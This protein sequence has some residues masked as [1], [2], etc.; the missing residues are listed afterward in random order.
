MNDWYFHL[1]GR[2]P[3]G[4]EDMVT[5]DFVRVSA[6]YFA[7]I[8]VP[9][10][11]GR[12]FSS[13]EARTSAKVVAISE[14]FAA[15]YFADQDPLGT[16]L[17]I[18][19][20]EAEAYEIVGIVGDVRHRSMGGRPRPA[21]YVPSLNVSPMNIVLRTAG[22]ENA[23]VETLRAVVASADSNQPVAR[24]ATMAQ[25]I[26]RSLAP[27]RFSTYLLG[28]F[29]LIALLLAGLGLFGVMAFS[30]ATRTKDIGIRMALGARASQVRAMVLREGLWLAVA[31]LALGVPGV[32]LANQIIGA[33]LPVTTT[34]MPMIGMTVALLLA[35]ASLACYIPARRAT[36]IAPMSVLRRD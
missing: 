13:T 33:L 16:R 30:V 1:E 35:T 2:P 15:R 22:D 3:S 7:T 18:G 9:L 29:G 21:M 34:A 25:L 14:S 19:A 27:V 12:D 4:P 8:D 32:L 28:N 36:R 5:A 11:R 10:R 23:M 24:S 26:G 17:M 31:G 20:P 6:D